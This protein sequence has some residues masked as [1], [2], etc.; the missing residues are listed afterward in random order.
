MSEVNR[1]IVLAERPHGAPAA[2]N[3]RLEE[4]PVPEPAAGELVSRTLYLS[5]DP[6]MRGRMSDAPSYAQPVAIDEVMTGGTVG[7]VVASRL[8]GFA[9]GDFVVGRGGWQNFSVY[10]AGEARKVG[11]ARAPLSTALGVLGMPGMTAYTGLHEIGRPQA[12]ETLVVAAA[13]G[14]VGAVVGQIAKIKGCRAVGIA[15]SRDKC[16]Y[17][18]D[19]LG[20]DACLD[21]RAAGFAD[22]LAAA[23]PKGVDVY[24]ENV[25]GPV[26]AAVLPLLNPFARIPVCGLIAQYNATELPAGP[27]RLPLLFRN[28]LTKRLTIRGFIVTDFAALEGEFQ[29]EVGAWMR[30]GRIR[31]REDIR[32]GLENAPEAFM[33]LLGGAN[34][35]KLLVRVAPDPAI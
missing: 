19:E 2:S 24:W 11:P 5:L 27:D 34:F 21:H 6:Y 4:V 12:G 18:V 8:D 20:F 13:S 32:D 29:R 1:R 10:K 26:F 23:C 14:A 22:A 17:V 7:Q 28:V 35:G 16:D 33:G 15:G 9:A 30:D 25:G 3:F 31:Y